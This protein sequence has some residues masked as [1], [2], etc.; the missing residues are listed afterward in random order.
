MNIQ[1]L[2]TFKIRLVALLVT[3]HLT[4]SYYKLLLLKTKSLEGRSQRW[5]PDPYP[6]IRRAASGIL[7][8][9]LTPTF[10][11]IHRG[12]KTFLKQKY[13]NSSFNWNFNDH[14]KFSF[15]TYSGDLNTRPVFEWQISVWYYN[16]PYFECFVKMLAI[17][18]KNIQK[19]DKIVKFLNGYGQNDR[20][21][22]TQIPKR[23]V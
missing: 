23:P 15:S 2:K 5:K 13:A 10:S 19:L 11:N 6:P 22:V 20:H 4:A 12:L 14:K 18:Y 1:I 17:L 8:I 3:Q 21:F 7:K 9:L 16:G